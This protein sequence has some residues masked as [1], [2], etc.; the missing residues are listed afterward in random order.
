MKKIV[1]ILFTIIFIIIL[2]K[3]LYQPKSFNVKK[4][5]NKDKTASFTYKEYTLGATSGWFQSI[6][7]NNKEI[8]RYKNSII[9]GRWISNHKIKLLSD[10]LPTKNYIKKSPYPIHIVSIPQFKDSE[11]D[12]SMI[13][14]SD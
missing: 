12:S 13:R 14:L 4:V 11:L 8:L 1:L 10:K 7:I 6:E 5:Y 9:Y 3:I 2:I